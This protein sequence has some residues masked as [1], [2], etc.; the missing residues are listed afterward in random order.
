MFITMTE[1]AFEVGCRIGR[2]V[3]GV[4]PR[5]APRHRSA[6]ATI[7]RCI[8]IALVVHCAG[9]SSEYAVDRGALEVLRRLSSH[10]RRRIAVPAVR[11][12]DDSRVYLRGD[13]IDPGGPI[14]DPQRVVVK[15]RS[16]NYPAAFGWPML[17]T[18]MPAT[19]IFGIGDFI[20]AA[21]GVS[22]GAE[23]YGLTIAGALQIIAGIALIVD[24]AVHPPQEVSADN[25]RF[26]FP[27][28]RSNQSQ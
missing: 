6:T 13:S 17:L 23:G 11:K 9:C 15:A 19:A 10:D 28:V 25:P 5:A 16:F 2:S 4:V 24:G 3:S 26:I 20:V 22:P 8:A 14:P 27:D 7:L 18:G 12:E 21:N 1:V